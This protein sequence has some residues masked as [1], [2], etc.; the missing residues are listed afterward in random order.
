MNLEVIMDFW[1][2]YYPVVI[3]IGGTIVTV[4]GMIFTAWLVVKPKID[5]FKQWLETIKNKV[6]DADAEDVSTTLQSVDI[7]TKITDLQ[8]KIN[9]PLTSDSAR[10]SYTKQLEILITVKTKLDAGLVTVEET[11]SKY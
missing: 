9:N 11:T 6:T 8:E 7:E 2:T 1:N 4:G 10:A 5:L 3:A